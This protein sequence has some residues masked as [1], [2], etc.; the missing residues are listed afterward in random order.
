L[1]RQLKQGQVILGIFDEGYVRIYNAIIDD[2]LLNPCGIYKKRLSKLAL[3]A[4]T[5]P[6]SDQEASWARTCRVK[7]R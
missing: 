5:R 7:K 2:E 1:A 6:V 4:E 3:V